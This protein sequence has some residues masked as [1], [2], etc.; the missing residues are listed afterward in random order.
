M[1]VP[2]NQKYHARDISFELRKGSPPRCAERKR[3]QKILTGLSGKR[4]HRITDEQIKTAITAHT[5][6]VQEGS[7]QGD[8]NGPET[9]RR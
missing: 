3:L 7:R 8:F 5:A 6:V 9:T 4:D 2:Q 1:S